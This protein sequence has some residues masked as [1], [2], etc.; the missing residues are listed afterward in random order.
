MVYGGCGFMA[1]NGVRNVSNQ[2]GKISRRI[3]L[4]GAQFHNTQ[5]VSINIFQNLGQLRATLIFHNEMY[6]QDHIK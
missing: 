3:E 5:Q 4:A 6:L 2:S 1:H